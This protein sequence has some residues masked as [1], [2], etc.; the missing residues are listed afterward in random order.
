MGDASADIRTVHKPIALAGLWSVRTKRLALAVCGLTTA[1][2][3]FQLGAKSFWTDEAF[4]D[5]MAHLGV[6]TA[7]KAIIRGD[8]FNGLYY[9]LLHLWQF[10]GHSETWLRLPS[11]AF[12]IL[13]AYTL[14][15]LNRR[16]FGVRV[17]VASG[18]LLAVNTFFVYYEQDARPYT[19]TTFL[20]VLA[21][22]LLVRAMEAGSTTRWLA[23]GLVGALSIY[24]HFFAAF[25]IAAHL[26]YVVMSVATGY[27][28]RRVRAA[29]AGYGLIAVLVAPLVVAVLRTDSLER[30]FIDPVSLGSFRWLFLNLTGAGG[31]P[32]GG[33][34]FLLFGY[35]AMCCLAILWMAKAVGR[36]HRDGTD[37]VRSFA[38]ELSWL[39]VPILGSFVISL[40]RSPIFYP[41]YLIVALPPLVTIAGIGIAGFPR[42]WLQYTAAAILLALSIHPLLSYYRADFIEGENWRGAVAYVTQ[43]SQPGDGIVFLSRYG[44]RSFEYYLRRFGTGADLTP[45]YPSMPWGRYVPVLA[46]EH[47]ESS[48]TA[49][50]RLQDYRRVWVVLLWEGFHSVDEDPLPFTAT[51]ESSYSETAGHAFGGQLE[52]RLYQ[53]SGG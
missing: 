9:G 24:A 14:F 6:S 26:V 47:I 17:A 29:A 50:G 34:I 21:T 30:R 46:D 10:G 49:A 4:S 41:R 27:R 25:V 1:L 19:L 38:L 35:F 53:R 15:L 45:I 51:L 12:G 13:A 2:G 36:R 40:V 16:L 8:A 33:G 44:R 42:R 43:A 31:V 37:R 22:Y 18:A 39:A 7:W 3:A 20:V 23:Y 11:V 32:T 52:I 28:G 48:V 5:A